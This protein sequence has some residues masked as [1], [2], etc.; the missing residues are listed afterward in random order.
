MSA[1]D[2]FNSARAYKRELTGLPL[3]QEDVDLLNAATIGRWAPVECEGAAKALADPQAFFGVV[4]RSFGSLEQ[5]QVEGFNVLLE[6]MGTARWPIAWTA[7]GL[8][9]A[10]HE[11]AHTM[12]PVEEAFWKNDAWRKRNL[13]YYPWHGRGYVQLTWKANYEKA[14]DELNLGEA[15]LADPRLAM[16]PDIAARILVLGMERGWFTKKRLADYLPID[17]EAGHEAFKQARRIIN[18]TDKWSEI[19][20]LAQVFQS[21]L[22]VGAWS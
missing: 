1:V 7:Y 6:A 15:M 13:R 17:G 20:K 2:F 21:A 19:A 8:A 11:T 12:Q 5:K 3:S 10:W 9:T 14:S 18:G 4:R 22:Q 16:R